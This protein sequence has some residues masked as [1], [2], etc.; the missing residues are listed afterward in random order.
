MN[1][2]KSISQGI[3]YTI[4]WLY[5]ILIAIGILC[6]F[7][8]EYRTNTNWV[9]SFLNGK[10]NYSKQLIFAGVCAIIATLILLP[11]ANYLLHLPISFMYLVFY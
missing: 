1:R 9:Q 11:T 8:V 4:I 6:I 10:T 3:D 2:Q 5:G 7:M